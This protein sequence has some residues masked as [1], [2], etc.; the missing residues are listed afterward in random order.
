MKDKLHIAG[1]ILLNNYSDLYPYVRQFYI[2]LK[3][4]KNSEDEKVKLSGKEQKDKIHAEFTEYIKIIQSQMSKEEL[5]IL[6]YASFAFKPKYQELLAH[7][8]FFGSVSNN[9]LIEKEHDCNLDIK[10]KE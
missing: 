10:F 2:I 5:T 8:N 7:Y 6:Y 3:L 1:K 9:I 4:T